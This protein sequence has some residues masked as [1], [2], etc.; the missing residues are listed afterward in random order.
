MIQEDIWKMMIEQDKEIE[1]K[2]LKDK[3]TMADLEDVANGKECPYQRTNGKNQKYCYVAGLFNGQRSK[4]IRLHCPYISKERDNDS[5][6]YPC[7]YSPKIVRR[8]K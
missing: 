3:L 5:Q 7:S 8:Y 1:A 2:A 6:K 4:L